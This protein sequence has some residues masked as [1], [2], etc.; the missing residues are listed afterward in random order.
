MPRSANVDVSDGRV[1]QRLTQLR[2]R[3]G[4]TKA[5]LAASAGLTYRTVH[6]LESGRR[7]RV[8]EKTL[9]L[10]VE[11]LGASLQDVLPPPTDT[12]DAPSAPARAPWY[13][14]RHAPLA[15]GALLVAVVVGFETTKSHLVP[16]YMPRGREIR[17]EVPF[18]GLA[19]WTR[20]YES[21]VSFY[22]PSPWT[23]DLLLVGL[24]S[25][26]ADGGRLL[27]LDRRSGA[28][29]WEVGPDVSQLRAAFGDS[30]VDDAYFNVAGMTPADMDGDGTPELALRI[31]HGKW[32]PMAIA[33]VDRE[34]TRLGQYE[35]PGHVRD[36][37][38]GDL[39]D[40]GRDELFLTGTV[41]CDA[42]EG[43]TAIVLDL[44]GLSGGAPPH[45]ERTPGTIPTD[46]APT[47]LILCNYPPAM[48]NQFETMRLAAHSPKIVRG[49]DGRVAL[50]L[51]VGPRP[52]PDSSSDAFF[53][54]TPDLRVA[55]V[56]ITDAFHLTILASWPDSLQPGPTDPA[57]LREWT[58]TFI[59]YERGRRVDD[60][61]ESR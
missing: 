35:H 53:R 5:E 29:Q 6:D 22:R 27:A 15:V 19:A 10:L 26:A 17:A 24:G 4:L 25:D 55:S 11:A 48:M 32:F 47:R 37:V 3:E 13:R 2:L 46:D 34:G 49:D 43:A 58:R 44:E 54:L 33:V 1:A 18:L 50:T 28:I 57:W 56:G 60:A 59:R 16:N 61:A 38:A 7:P 41:N 39:D 8:Q 9:I 42:H 12:E 36:F 30:I 23:D 20:E 40:D 14:R 45:D 31:N 52:H 51:S 21:R